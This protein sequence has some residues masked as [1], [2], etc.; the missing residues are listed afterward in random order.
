MCC[1]SAIRPAD[2][3]IQNTA[4]RFSRRRLYGSRHADDANRRRTRADRVAVEDQRSAGDVA[5]E[6][7]RREDRA[8]I[9]KDSR[10][11]AFRISDCQKDAVIL[12]GIGFTRAI[13]NEATGSD[14]VYGADE[15]VKVRVVAE[16]E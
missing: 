10:R 14:T 4:N 8:N 1:R 7:K 15:I 2:E 9:P 6:R 13:N 12:V 11:E 16:Q 3:L 5:L